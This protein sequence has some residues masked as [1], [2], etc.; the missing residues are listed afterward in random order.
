MALIYSLAVFL[1]FLKY[2]IG[3]VLFLWHLP[4]V[5]LGCVYRCRW[6]GQLVGGL[7]QD[8]LEMLS[9]PEAF[10]SLIPL[11]SASLPLL[12]PHLSYFVA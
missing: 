9:G 2:C 10:V 5:T 11:I 12:L 1:P 8:T 7:L 6:S 3:S 4:V